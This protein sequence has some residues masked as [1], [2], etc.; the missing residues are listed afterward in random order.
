MTGTMRRAVTWTAALLIFGTA[1]YSLA[2]LAIVTDEERIDSIIDDVASARHKGEALLRS[3]DLSRAPLEVSVGRDIEE[4]RSGDDDVLLGRAAEV[5]D[6]LGTGAL[7]VRQ[8]EITIDGENAHVIV[9]LAR[10]DELIPCDLTLRRSGA[11]WLI[12]RLRVM[13]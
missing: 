9:N 6:Q 1:S 7:E 13:G 5:D 8:R 12:A 4:F 11:R 2:D 10:G 3:V